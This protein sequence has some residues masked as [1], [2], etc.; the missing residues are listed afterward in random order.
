[1]TQP[2]CW[3]PWCE[4]V[5]QLRWIWR[6]HCPQGTKLS[7]CLAYLL[8]G[9]ISFFGLHVTPSQAVFQIQD[10]SSH[11]MDD[12]S[13][14]FLR[15]SLTV[16]AYTQ[17]QSLYP[18]TFSSSGTL[19]KITHF[20]D[21]CE[22]SHSKFGEGVGRMGL[23]WFMEPEMCTCYRGEWRGTVWWVVCA[24]SYLWQKKN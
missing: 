23:L 8:L 19:A 6:I 10:R 21:F 16:L 24:M 13:D 12:S 5:S 17:A 4:Q 15:A 1:M 3:P 22:S 9:Q 14:S 20:C 7:S 18:P 11:L 2:P